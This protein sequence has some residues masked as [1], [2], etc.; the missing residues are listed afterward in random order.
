MMQTGTKKKVQGEKKQ[1]HSVLQKETWP[2]ISENKTS[3]SADS[4]EEVF[5]LLEK[6][7]VRIAP[8]FELKNVIMLI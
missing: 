6:Q 7:M 3:Q 4:K 1:L 2:P 8:V 5:R